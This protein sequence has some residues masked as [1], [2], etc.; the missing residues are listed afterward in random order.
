MP[1]VLMVIGMTIGQGIFTDSQN[2]IWGAH[3][4]LLLVMPIRGE[5]LRSPGCKALGTLGL[6]G[7]ALVGDS[8][9]HTSS[10]LRKVPV[11][12]GCILTQNI[13]EWDFHVLRG[14][15]SLSTTTLFIF[16]PLRQCKT[17]TKESSDW[18]IYEDQELSLPSGR[19]QAEQVRLLAW[20]AY[21]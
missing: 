18:L 8:K 21:C 15:G 2:R 7:Y 11:A 6:S 17:N 16:P 9:H 3:D 20:G 1:S 4:I 10:I 13:S 14:R 12:T 5:D 19:P